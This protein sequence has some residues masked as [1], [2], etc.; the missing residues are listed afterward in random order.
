MC[1]MFH[2]TLS[3]PVASL[4]ALLLLLCYRFPRLYWPSAEQQS[5]KSSICV[6][7]VDNHFAEGYNPTIENTF[8]KVLKRRGVE[9][10]VE[11]IDTAG[12]VRAARY[13]GRRGGRGE[14]DED[15]GEFSF[16]C[17]SVG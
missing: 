4:H 7:F 3:V 2:L 6:Q 9:Y 14:D 1:I 16:L 5:G 11:I 12:Q 15:R 10:N 8:H 13:I 17:G